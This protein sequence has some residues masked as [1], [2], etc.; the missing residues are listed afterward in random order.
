MAA[1]N[2]ADGHELD[3]DGKEGRKR[4]GDRQRGTRRGRG[5]CMTPAPARA[6]HATSCVLTRVEAAK[7]GRRPSVK[8][9]E[10]L[11]PVTTVAD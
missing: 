5:G 10:Q 7:W 6:R 1:V 11:L 4:D 3:D 9:A 8:Q 2:C